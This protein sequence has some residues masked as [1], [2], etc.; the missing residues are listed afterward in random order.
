MRAE[1]SDPTRL[2]TRFTNRRS[3]E[4]LMVHAGVH[5]GRAELAPQSRTLEISG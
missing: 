3:I 2:H 1:S 5:G 4:A